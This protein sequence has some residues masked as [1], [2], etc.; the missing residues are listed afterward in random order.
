M[1]STHSEVER[2]EKYDEEWDTEV[3]K[4][5]K[6]QEDNSI[7]ISKYLSTTLNQIMISTLN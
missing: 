6:Q 3:S 5:L 2:N 1:K 4:R 7:Y